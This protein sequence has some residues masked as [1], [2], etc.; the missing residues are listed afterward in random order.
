MFV[1]LEIVSQTFSGWRKTEPEKWDVPK[2]NPQF[3]RLYAHGVL[4]LRG[5]TKPAHSASE[6]LADPRNRWVTAF[7]LWRYFDLAHRDVRVCG[8]IFPVVLYMTSNLVFKTDAQVAFFATSMSLTASRHKTA[9]EK[10]K[11]LRPQSLEHFQE[12]QK[13]MMLQPHLRDRFLASGGE[14]LVVA[15]PS[16][17]LPDSIANLT[18]K[19]VES[20]NTRA[21]HID[22][23]QVGTHNAF[24]ALRSRS[25]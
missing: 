1:Y 3:S 16:E 19:D 5:E 22:Q 13:A 10:T 4:Q 21:E 24:R 12:G 17:Q 15:V 8:R 25:Q 14:L 18:G 7:L 2:T 6:N 20:C 9:K 23:L 11:E